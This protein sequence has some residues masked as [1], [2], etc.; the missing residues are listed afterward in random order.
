RL[1]ALRL[2]AATPGELEAVERHLAGCARCRSSADALDATH[3]QFVEVWV[4]TRGAL[5]ER[6]GSRPSERRP[7][8]P[9]RWSLFA[10]APALA[11]V[12]ILVVVRPRHHG[13]G[14]LASEP[15]LR[16]KG[17]A[18]L[19]VVARRGERV[20][21]A[22]G[23]PLRAGDRIRFVLEGVEYPFVM[24]ASVDG[25]GRA[26]LYVPYEGAES[27]PVPAHEAGAE[28][29]ALEGSIV[30]DRSPGPE[31]LFALFSQRPL[32]AAP[33]RAALAAIAVGGPDAIRSSERLPWSPS[34]AVGPGP[35]L[36]RTV[37]LE[38]VPE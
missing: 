11:A 33:V 12:L 18:G 28:E 35:D 13:G 22:D 27:S 14:E 36:Q 9:A 19:L 8:S 38:K 34:D 1:E 3:R 24:I 7:W 17:E 37:L 25:N 29:V 4:K 30:L 26:N 6:A 5:R 2:G 32:P 31:R 15:V 10:V 21:P 16:S 23:E 20:F